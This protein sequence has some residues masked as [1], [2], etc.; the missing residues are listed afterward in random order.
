MKRTVLLVI[1]ALGLGLGTSAQR[2]PENVTPESYDLKFK[3]KLSNATFS[4]DVTIHVRLLKPASSIVLNSAEIEFQ[5]ATIAAGGSVQTASVSLDGKNETA[6]LAVPRAIPAGVADI[7]IRYKGV[8]NDQLRGFYLSQTSRRRYAVTQFEATD[9][10]RAFPSFDEP[11]YKAVFR[12]TL[13]VDKG[14]TAIS[15]GRIIS[16]SPGP[17]DTKHTLQFSPS[18]KMSTYLVAMMVGDFQCLEGG[19][20]GIPVRV[21]AVPEK[22]GLLSFALLSAENILKFYDRYYD[23]K[24]PFQKLDIIAFPDFS[25]GA[26]ENTAAI[27]YRETLLT[28]DDKTASVDAHQAVV[29]VLAH[30]MA[31]QWFGD[32][33]TMKWWDDIWLNEG[34]ATWMSWK[35]VEA[36]KPEWHAE[37]NEI[38]ETGGSL[39]TDSIA[40]VR[41]VRAK[42]ETPA[43]IQTL[44]D[45]VA[46]GKAA[47]VLRMV[48]AYVGPEVFRKAVNAYLEKH[49][50]GNATAE[51]FWNQ[52]AATSGK[53]VDKIMAG[54]TQQSGAPLVTV[55]TACQGNTTQVTLAQER[56]FA[57]A[58]RLAAGSTELWLIP[59]HLRASGSKDAAYR[60]LS[61]RRQT[62]E[63]PGCSPWVYANVG[64][65]G[66]YRTSYDPTAFA[67]MSAELETAFSPEERIHFLGDAW[68]MVRVGRLNIGDYLATLEKMQAERSRAVMGLMMERFGELHGHV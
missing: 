55:K 25:A 46:Y 16:D 12:I 31:H 51:D 14:D 67:K 44:F 10:R 63:L 49:A 32:L 13:V 26:M 36:W 27:T 6:T 19:A 64:G 24:Y 56:Y 42:A 4:G 22:K 39:G 43:E 7:H 45:G 41:A 5:E 52:V 11:A 35:P 47:S 1:F 48:E 34:F 15:N 59:V 38:Q 57:N 20:D 17:G 60:P 65:R 9:A 66:H 30:E 18:P 2:L 37:R 68:A 3:P 8:L 61:E 40:S 50:Y 62:F 53:P 29:G 28:I 54:F 23:I 33:V 21:C 58:A